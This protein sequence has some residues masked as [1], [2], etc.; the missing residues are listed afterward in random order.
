MNK[1]RYCRISWWRT[2][3]C[4]SGLLRRLPSRLL[5]A[6]VGVCGKISQGMMFSL[7]LFVLFHCWTSQSR[8]DSIRPRLVT[9]NRL[10]EPT[11]C[12]CFKFSQQTTTTRVCV[13]CDDRG[14]WNISSWT[15][16]P[17]SPLPVLQPFHC[18]VAKMGTRHACVTAAGCWDP[19]TGGG[20]WWLVSSIHHLLFVFVPENS[21]HSDWY[22]IRLHAVCWFPFHTE[23]RKNGF[24]FKIFWFSFYRIKFGDFTK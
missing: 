8:I 10:S 15:P 20:G 6:V 13:C 5:S 19:H 18:A 4:S 22:T 9:D 16:S 11:A 21:P 17:T 12:E 3:P 23:I 2:S 1:P 24:F 7:K 14:T